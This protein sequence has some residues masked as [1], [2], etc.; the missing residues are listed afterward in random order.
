MSKASSEAWGKNA[1]S[2][3]IQVPLKQ[4]WEISHQFPHMEINCCCCC[5]ITSMAAPSLPITD[6]HSAEEKAANLNS[7]S[8]SGAPHKQTR[9]LFSCFQLAEA[10]KW[11][12]LITT[13]QRTNNNL[14]NQHWRV[15]T[16]RQERK[17]QYPTIPTPCWHTWRNDHKTQK[18]KSK[19]QASGWRQ[20][21]VIDLWNDSSLH[22][23]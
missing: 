10:G 3:S 19:N 12:D 13:G 15:C 9:T 20:N 23:C 22:W 21:Y 17:I 11:T 6:I 14:S 2:M 18:K 7:T 1:A 5:R 16:S 8:E 4:K